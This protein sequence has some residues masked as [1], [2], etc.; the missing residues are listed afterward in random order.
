MYEVK[1]KVGDLVLVERGQSDYVERRVIYIA[2]FAGDG[3]GLGE[4]W[5]YKLDKRPKLI[6]S[7]W[8]ADWAI[9]AVIK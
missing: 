8:V 5:F 7:R 4:K 9:K 2:S 1:C 6:S 3:G